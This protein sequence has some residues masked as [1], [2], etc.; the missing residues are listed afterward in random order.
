MAVFSITENNKRYS[1]NLFFNLFVHGLSTTPFAPFLK[2]DLT[3]N[4]LL[5]LG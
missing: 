1:K 3:L 5:V 4:K 2:L